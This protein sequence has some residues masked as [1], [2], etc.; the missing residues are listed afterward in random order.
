MD[1][2]H[3]GDCLSLHLS[4]CTKHDE[5]LDIKETI[6]DHFNIKEEEEEEE[7]TVQVHQFTDKV[8]EHACD[9]LTAKDNYKNY[10]MI[11]KTTF[12]WTFKTGMESHIIYFCPYCGRKLQ[13][14]K[15]G[16]E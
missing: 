4:P 14:A 8:E 2:G 16:Q 9:T 10:Y 13:K 7:V 15:L 6:R 1:V 12:G 3:P 11:V 5:K